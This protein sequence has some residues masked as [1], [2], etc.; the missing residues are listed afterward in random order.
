MK[1]QTTPAV[2]VARIQFK[3]D[4]RKVCFQVKSSDNI[5]VYTCCLFNGKVT[6]CSCPA[7]V[8]NCRHAQAAEAA[9]A[10]R[11]SVIINARR[12]RLEAEAE[13]ARISREAAE[14]MTR[15]DASRQAEQ[16]MSETA[17]AYYRMSFQEF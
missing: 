15:T 2:I 11:S 9:E 14:M 10:E 4:P 13:L 17:A 12:R 8:L 16:P 6:S 7:R 1:N 5:T 3:N